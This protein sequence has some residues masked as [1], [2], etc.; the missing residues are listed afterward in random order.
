[1][2]SAGVT[3]PGP[4]AGAHGRPAR[5][6]PGPLRRTLDRV[7]TPVMALRASL[8]LLWANYLFAGRW[9]EVPGALHGAREPFYVA[10]LGA[11]TLLVLSR[12][13]GRGPADVRLP[14]RLLL[15]AGLGTLLVGLFVFWFPVTDWQR[16]PFLDN[17]PARY[18]AAIDGIALLRRGAIVGWQWQFL[19][20][21]HLS[22]DI[23][24][25][26]AVLAFLPVTLFGGPAG[27]H[28]LHVLLFSAVPLIVWI[29]LRREY[30]DGIPE[31]AAAVAALTTASVAYALG[32]SGDTNS[33]AGVVCVLGA[34]A[35]SHAA[36]RGVRAGGPL[37]VVCLGLAYYSHAGFI[38][39]AGIY[40][41]AE[42]LFYRDRHTVTRAVVA[43]AAAAIV[44]LPLTWETWRHPEFFNFNNRIYDPDTPFHWADFLQKIYYN[45]EILFL[46]WRWFNDFT[47]L[48][49]VFAPVMLFVAITERSRAGFYAWVVLLTLALTRLHTP[50]FGYAFFRPFYMLVAVT[51]PVLAWFIARQSGTRW[52]AATLTALIGIFV[53][54]WFGAVPHVARVNEYTAPLIERI[55]RSDGALVLVENSPHRNMNASPGG[56]VEPKPFPAHFEAFLAAETGRRLYA[57]LWDGWQWSPWRGQLVA[58]GAFM[59]R[60]LAET[61]P[62]AFE[63]ELQRWGIRHLLVWSGTTNGYLTGNPNFVPGW[64]EGAWTEYTYL[65][66]DPR[67]VATASGS[68]TLA[69]YDPLGA[70]IELTGVGAG[71]E[72]IVRTN[73]YPVWQARWNGRAVSLHERDGQ[74]AFHAPAAG[75]FRV[76]LVYPRRPWL[77][78]LA[79]GALVAA[80][81]L[82]AV[83]GSP[84]RSREHERSP[85]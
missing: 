31:L 76:E 1:M 79:F 5:R 27:F 75:D 23:T 54:V 19:G 66:A 32:K 58:G 63:A 3:S 2:T 69:A 53:Q 83:R 18:Q 35:A 11:A 72:V 56:R 84:A 42:C 52:L 21:Y 60:G 61:A 81:W 37:Q 70:S 44:A 20:G 45:I 34:M 6:R 67:S 29:D 38:L 17:W 13:A 46:P 14:A 16:L 51:A 73:Y 9:A 49:L 47:A 48:A 82:L 50:Q 74:L 64:S 62:D 41:A 12:R 65:R 8:V 77:W 30:R 25:S 59:G 28:L 26:L 57:G 80:S 4:A 43:M 33:L 15:A 78:L 10:A 68:G 39:Y 24:V 36:R 55:R 40:L 7:V 71:D 22:S 85:A